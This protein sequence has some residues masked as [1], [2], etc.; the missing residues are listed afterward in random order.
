MN[1]QRP[2]GDDPSLR[3]VLRQWSVKASLPPRF[4]AEVWEQIARS[5]SRPLPASKPTW[6]HWLTVQLAQPAWAVS[7]IAILLVLGLAG[8]YWHGTE[9]QEQKM[10][11]LRTRYVQ[12]VNP[13]YVQHQ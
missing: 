8:G 9:K 3:Q 6:W 10:E 4:Q 5:E 13:Y 2:A 7:Y 12:S 1:T 11:A